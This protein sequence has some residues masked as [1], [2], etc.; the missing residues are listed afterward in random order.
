M[1]PPWVGLETLGAGWRDWQG[2]DAAP[3]ASGGWNRPDGSGV[4]S[5]PE[6]PKGAETTGDLK[7][8]Q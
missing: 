1:A 8:A 3:S 7:Q 2:R 5:L 6:Q 4:P